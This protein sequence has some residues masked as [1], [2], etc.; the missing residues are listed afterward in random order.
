MT[1]TNHPFDAL[2]SFAGDFFHPESSPDSIDELKEQCALPEDRQW[3]KTRRFKFE[4][5][6]VLLG[7]RDGLRRDELGDEAAFGD[8]TDELFLSRVW[9]ECFPNEPL[10]GVPNGP[11]D[12]LLR[13]LHCYYTDPDPDPEGNYGDRAILKRHL[14][15]PAEQQTPIL[16]GVKPD[17]TKVLTGDTDGMPKGGIYRRA[18]YWEPDD[19]SF[20]RALW[21]DLFPHDPVPGEEDRGPAGQRHD[22]TPPRTRPP[23]RS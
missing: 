6:E 12:A 5:K 1:D 17:L 22:L 21:T 13:V 19:L 3:P 18:P 23:Q 2:L 11:F 7:H 10:P 9:T 4:M 16:R 15:L 14:A 8:G 20:A